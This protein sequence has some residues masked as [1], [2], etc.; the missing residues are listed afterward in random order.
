M[1]HQSLQIPPT[2]R[3]NFCLPFEKSPG[4][5]AKMFVFAVDDL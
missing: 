5:R 1:I 3:L 4:A 2:L